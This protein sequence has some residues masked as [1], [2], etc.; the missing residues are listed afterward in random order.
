MH[1]L[2]ETLHNLGHLQHARDLHR[3]TLAARRRVLG[4]DHPNILTSV[5]S[6][7]ETLRDLGDLK[8][9]HDL[10]EHALSGRR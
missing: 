6:L 3:Q 10:H 9:A 1:N 2:A 4:D 8:G 7:A 5:H